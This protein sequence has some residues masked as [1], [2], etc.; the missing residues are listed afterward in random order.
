MEKLSAE[1]SA[2]FADRLLQKGSRI[3]TLFM[4]FLSGFILSGADLFTVKVPLGVGLAAVC[5]G[6]ELVLTVL[7]VAL[8]GLLRLDG[9][10]MLCCLIPLAGTVGS[11]CILEKLRIRQKRT[12]ILAV[13]VFLICF[14]V[15]TILM[16]SEKNASLNKF[17]LN[18]CS[19]LFCF[20]SVFFYSGT[21]NCIKHSRKISTLDNHSLICIMM[22]LCTLLLGL[23]EI[24]IL[25]FRPARLFGCFVIICASSLFAQAGGSIAG[26]SMG[27]CV[28]VSGTSVALSLCYGIS[29]LASGIFSKYG[30]FVCALIFTAVTGTAAIIDA[31]PEGVAVFAEAA[32]ASVIFAAI[33]K[34]F[35]KT[36]KE[37]VVLPKSRRLHYESGSAKAKILGASEAISSVSDCVKSVSKGIDAL[38]PANDIIVCMR[39]KERICADCK[40]KDSFCPENG[41]F[42]AITEKLSRG[43]SIRAEDF[44]LNFNTKCPSVPRIADCFNRLYANRS[45]INALQASSARSRELACGQ[46][47]WISDLLRELSDEI[48]K[49]SQIHFLKEKTA[50]R[51]LTDRDFTVKSVSCVQ[52]FSGALKLV[53]T[54]EDI[55]PAT[56]LS[57]LTAALSSELEAEFLP[58]KIKEVKG[59]KE[60]IFKRK[61]IYNVTL[62]TASSSCGNKKLCGDYSECFRTESKVYVILSDG[63]G[64]GG[65]AA[66]DSAMTVELFSRLIRAGI[67]LDTALN[68]TNSALA[69]KSDDESLSTLDV[70][71]ID[72]FSGKATVYKAG[73]AP[74]FY[75]CSGR[76]KFIETPS[77]PLGILNKASFSKYE[78]NFKGGD[79]LVMM[80]DGLL[81]CGSLWI[82]NEIAACRG[83][84]ATDFS[85]LILNT[86]KR[87]C[88]EKYDDMTVITV[89][90][91]EN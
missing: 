25:G 71:E 8:G 30:Q 42:A 38:A 28:A 51:V 14:G 81:G 1:H 69:V 88:G 15:S 48:D 65:R 9:T 90:V 2:D 12:V 72:V 34:K 31:T 41:D 49:Q 4:H 43:E 26:I 87:K 13:S 83:T 64:T 89:T 58:P 39:V 66:I 76:V 17:L 32:V 6:N 35:L 37:T 53:C 3:F 57:Y 11:V 36:V 27:A 78:I 77:T 52:P 29:G 73:A 85:E 62:G 80:S 63:M 67:S 19:S 21:V 59:G 60:L 22:S 79:M 68:I 18:L 54:V 40:L 44:S 61:E 84:A 10:D 16:F 74:S 91:E 45:A 56:S 82:Q 5:T 23:S 55:P 75:T 46:F 7:G 47:D 33:P 24:S 70:A 50:A 86:A 20:G